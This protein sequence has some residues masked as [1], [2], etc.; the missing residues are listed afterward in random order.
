EAVRVLE[1]ALQI[2]IED[3]SPQISEMQH[4]IETQLSLVYVFNGW[5][6]RA[7]EVS[8]RVRSH[9]MDNSNNGS[10][11]RSYLTTSVAQYCLGD[12]LSAE[13]T[14]RTGLELARSMHSWQLA[15]ML[16]M[17]LGRSLLQL[18]DIDG[19]LE[20]VRNAIA[21]GQNYHFREIEAESLSILGDIHLMLHDHGE[22]AKIYLKGMDLHPPGFVAMENLY[23]WG[24]A[25]YKINNDVE[26]IESLEHCIQTGRKLGLWLIVLPA[27]LCR[28]LVDFWG[29][30]NTAARQRL[31]SVAKEAEQRKIVLLPVE[32]E[33]LYSRLAWRERKKEVADEFAYSLIQ[34]GKRFHNLWFEISGKHLLL[35]HATSRAESS[36]AALELKRSLEIMDAHCHD[37]EFRPIFLRFRQAMLKH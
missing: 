19:A 10:L 8:G 3:D 12:Y 29:E 27:E 18:G 6:E 1:S 11:Q 16:E 33:W 35:E 28:A 30:R 31:D 15:G 25:R 26:G 4:N 24:Y 13:E 36:R 17:S 9:N 5:P 23:R 37:P 2:C 20:Q 7:M 22:A 21:L 32:S 14:A 34:K